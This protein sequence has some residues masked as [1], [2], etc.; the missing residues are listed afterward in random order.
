MSPIAITMI[1]FG[2]SIDAFLASLGRGAG[3]HRPRVSD[4]MRTGLVF[5]LVET[6]IALAGWCAGVVASP[7]VGTVDHWIAFGLLGLV[8]G[9][10]IYHAVRPASP[11]TAA[12]RHGSALVLVATA[13]GTSID[14]LAV[15]VSL[16]ILDVNMLV[17]AAAIGAATFV[18]ATGGM[19]AGR[20][21]GRQFGSWA[22]IA[23]GVGL[24]VLGLSIL[25]DH[26]V[27]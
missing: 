15:G 21:I 9:R 1:A 16:A 22:E 19:L 17:I 12:R 3:L 14:A 20:L 18:M 23:G 13:V 4:A 26:T 2:M 11:W 8:G 24:M 27:F 10:M 5:G 25:A 6:A 7:Y